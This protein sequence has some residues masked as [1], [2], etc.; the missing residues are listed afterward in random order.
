M[1]GDIVEMEK[2]HK[3]EMQQVEAMYGERIVSLHEKLQR[4]VL[5][6][7]EAAAEVG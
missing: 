2:E 5:R 1:I 4:A 7:K 3:A 6:N